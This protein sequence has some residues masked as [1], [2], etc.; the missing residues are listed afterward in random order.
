MGKD[1]DKKKSKDKDKKRK[2]DKDEDEARKRAKAERLVRSLIAAASSVPF[3][4]QHACSTHLARMLFAACMAMQR[5]GIAV[6]E[7]LSALRATTKMVL[8]GYE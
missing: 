3:E 6:S 1:K 7:T 5:M 4:P 8:S 2:R